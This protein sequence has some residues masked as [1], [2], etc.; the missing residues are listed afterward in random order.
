MLSQ[1]KD[2]PAS[3]SLVQ[4]IRL[5]AGK[6]LGSLLRLS[7]YVPTDASAES[8]TLKQWCVAADCHLHQNPYKSYLLHYR[9]EFYSKFIFV[10][11]E[12]QVT[13]MFSCFSSLLSCV[14]DVSVKFLMFVTFARFFFICPSLT[15]VDY[16]HVFHLCLIVCPT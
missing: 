8:E 16:L 7:P 9:F 4:Y 12:F 11:F 6:C 13:F 2:H 10:G 5:S 1:V 3:K 15:H 14:S